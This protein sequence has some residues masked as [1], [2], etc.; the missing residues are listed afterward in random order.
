MSASND[1]Q[2]SLN[3]VWQGLYSYPSMSEMVPFTATL[4]C[5]G[6]HVGGSAHETCMVAPGASATM[7]ALL[8][9]ARRSQ[10]IEFVKTYDG[11]GGWDHSV[12]YDGAINEDCTEIEGRWRVAGGLT[13]RFLMTRPDRKTRKSSVR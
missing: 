9:G 5:A 3:G 1:E 2:G 6:D 10:R 11:T 8:D 7:T 12:A 4:V 13:G